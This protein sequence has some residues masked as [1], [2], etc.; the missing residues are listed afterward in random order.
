MN[1]RY[2]TR[3]RNIS[4]IMMRLMILNF[5]RCRKRR[6]AQIATRNNKLSIVDE[7]ISSDLDKYNPRNIRTNGNKNPRISS[8]NPRLFTF[9]VELNTCIA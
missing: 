4:D 7:R 8:K 1:R 5:V 2:G 3:R 9:D 6:P